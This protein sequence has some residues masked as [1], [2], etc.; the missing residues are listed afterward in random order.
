MGGLLS[1]SAERVV[2]E[3]G[4]SASHLEGK[5][6]IVTGANTGIGLYTARVLASLG[7]EVILAGRNELRLSVAA[8]SIR[9]AVPNAKVQPLPLDLS[10]L[11]SVR[12][13]AQ[14]FLALEKPLHLLINNAGIM[15]P[16]YSLSVDGNELQF[17]TNHLGHFLLTQLLLERLRQSAPARVVCVSSLAHQMG[18]VDVDALNPSV[19]NYNPWRQY[20]VTKRCNVLFAKELARQLSGTG[21]TAFSLHPGSIP[22]E[23]GRNNVWARCYY[24]CLGCFQK[25]ISQG[26]ATTVYCAIQPGL[27]SL[28]GNYF[29]DCAVKQPAAQCSEAAV[30]RQLWER[31]QAL[32]ERVKGDYGSI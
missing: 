18:A 27:E 7:A 2:Q 30:A 29:A 11:A 19:E 4:V 9:S 1:K 22:T 24:T 10:S 14:A 3:S 25:S 32:V 8:S 6:A 17:A 20:G 23:L 21:V 28:S 12:R 13:F 15:A 31:S 26:A 16:G 5:V